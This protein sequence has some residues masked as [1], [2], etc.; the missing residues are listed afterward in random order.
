M[1]WAIAD[2]IELMLVPRKSSATIATRTISARISAYSAKPW[3]LWDLRT[4]IGALPF[5]GCDLVAD[6]G[7]DEPHE[8]EHAGEQAD[9]REP[10]DL[11]VRQAARLEPEQA[12]ADDPGDEQDP[13]EVFGVD[14]ADGAT[15][16]RGV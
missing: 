4:T 5:I 11:G 1:F 12:H 8:H 13:E 3:P 14:A 6:D 7:P 16:P 2:R 9:Q 15:H 10:A